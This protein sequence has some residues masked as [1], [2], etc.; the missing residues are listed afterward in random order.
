VLGQSGL[1]GRYMR[2]LCFM[3]DLSGKVVLVTGGS[4]GI[5]AAIVRTVATA[6]ARVVL[7]YGKGASQAEAISSE[8]GGGRC[9]IVHASL[10]KHGEAQSLWSQS[11]SRFG[12]IDVIVNNA[13]VYEPVSLD[14]DFEIWA[15]T[16]VH[17]LQVNLIAVADLCREA[18]RHYRSRGGGIIVNMASRAAFRG[19]SPEYLGYAASKGGILSLTRTIARG[20]ARDGIFA[21]A[22]APGFAETE[23]ISEYFKT[24]SKDDVIRDIPIGALVPVQE[25]A[26]VVAFLAS[27]LAHHAT[28]STIDLNGASY[29][30]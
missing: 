17:T 10:D 8:I 21:Y 6:G 19:D 28:G 25:V 26:N 12:R 20:Y 27:G 7:H 14:G 4:R 22:I 24:N 9:H 11:L 5:G 15:Q 13:G 1:S 29:V 30:R 2:L 23:M 16:W 18:I 3:I